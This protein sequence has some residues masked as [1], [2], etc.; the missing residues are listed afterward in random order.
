MS[1]FFF[2][3]CGVSKEDYQNVVEENEQLKSEISKL[4]EELEQ[5]MYGKERI[6][7]LIENAYNEKNIILARENIDLFIKY[8]PE[9]VSDANYKRVVELV[10]Q[11]ARK[12]KEAEEAIERNRI[13]QERLLN[14]GKTSDNPIIINGKS[15]YPWNIITN[16]ILDRAK[17][18]N[19]YITIE[20]YIYEQF[21]IN[22]SRWISGGSEWFEENDTYRFTTTR[23]M[24]DN[25]FTFYFHPADRD[26][27]SFVL[28]LN[29]KHYTE[30]Q[31]LNITGKLLGIKE[32][33]SPTVNYVFIVTQFTRRGIKYNGLI[34]D[35][36]H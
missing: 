31:L 17:Y 29:G 3:G 28:D 21:G 7:A 4:N 27:R 25:R 14:V 9:S 15:D 1:V 8:H 26:G 13:K 24:S 22:T 33:N 2:S 32:N 23:A 11:E 18:L 34:P 12:I 5:F 6:I 20:N 19:K 36:Y 30:D 10:E 16:I 35:E